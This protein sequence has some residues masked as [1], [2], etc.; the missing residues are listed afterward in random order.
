[1]CV[2]LPFYAS[3]ESVS[4]LFIPAVFC[5]TLNCET[6]LRGDLKQSKR[7]SLLLYFWYYF[8]KYEWFNSYDLQSQ[9]VK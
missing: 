3:V 2:N 8:V 5:A 4:S 7:P 6:H 9:E 1:M